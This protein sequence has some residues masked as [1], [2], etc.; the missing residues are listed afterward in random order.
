MRNLKRFYWDADGHPAAI[1]TRAGARDDEGFNTRGLPKC[2][3]ADT[4]MLL[5][6]KPNLWYDGMA[7]LALQSCADL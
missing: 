4:D 1:T 7:G 3:T 2:L 5:T 6:A